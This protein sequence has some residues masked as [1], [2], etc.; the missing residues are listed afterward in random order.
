MKRGAR[1]VITEQAL[2]QAFRIADDAAL[3]G[4]KFDAFAGTLELVLSRGR[5]PLVPEGAI[6]AIY[7]I[8]NLELEAMAQ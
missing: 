1:V 5:L 7:T 8:E 4:V 6:P 2:K 3:C